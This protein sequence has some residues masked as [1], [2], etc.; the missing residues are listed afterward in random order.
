MCVRSVDSRTPIDLAMLV[1]LSPY[2]SRAST[3]R[4]RGVSR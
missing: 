2:T 3:S 4:S 1:V